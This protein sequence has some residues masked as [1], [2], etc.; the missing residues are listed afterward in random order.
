MID[1]LPNPIIF[2][3][4]LPNGMSVP[5]SWHGVIVAFGALLAVY[6]AT[7]EV[8]RRGENPEHISNALIVALLLGVVGSRLYHIISDLAR[9][10]P[11]GY[12]RNPLNMVTGFSMG[13]GILGGVAGGILGLWLYTQRAGLKFSRWADIGAPS[14]ALAQAIGRWG[15]F[16]NQE[17]YGY[18]TTLP[19][20]IPI[21][22][23]HRLPQLAGLPASARFHPTFLYESLLDLL[24]FGVLLYVSRRWGAR[25][26]D[27]DLALLYLVL[28][29]LGR[30]FA[31]FQRPDAWTIGGIPTAQVIGIVSIVGASAVL[32][33]RHAGRRTHDTL[34][35][36][37]SGKQSEM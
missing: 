36:V 10:D 34:L 17:L 25:L 35:Q 21:D 23:G 19:W 9:G 33:Y 3:I 4:P 2:S 16:T 31:E 24:A 32:I 6:V 26:Q 18:P 15:N 1:F 13:L 8:R 22:A 37:D 5:I 27:G 7:F 28:Y 20:G 14:L 29:P 12:L 30:F 11:L